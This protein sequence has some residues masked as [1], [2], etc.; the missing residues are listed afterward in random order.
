VRTRP[1]N[2]LRW[3]GAG[4]VAA[5]ALV[6]AGCSPERDYKTLSIFFDGVPDP[7][8]KGSARGG[9]SADAAKRGAL[10]KQAGVMVSTHKPF[11]E[12]NCTAC[13]ADPAARV[14]A[15]AADAN[16]CLNCHAK[17][18]DAYAVMHG[19]VIGKACL[20]CHEPHESTSPW[21]LKTQAATLCTQCHERETLTQRTAGHRPDA[22]GCLDCH[23]G[24][25]GHAL[26]F[27]RADATTRPAKPG[28]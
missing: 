3:G 2:L 10:A 18:M 27:L 8:A 5:A 17:V 24:H 23:T 9:L 4:V 11:A 21:L 28:P 20:W 1:G 6:W 16:A 22:A 13:H 15:S 25:G 19:P 7:R 12:E 26:P 14:L